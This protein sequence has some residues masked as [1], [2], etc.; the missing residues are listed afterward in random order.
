[1]SETRNEGDRVEA[2]HL[3]LL[4]ELRDRGTL[5]AVATATHRT[6]SAVS[7][8]LR[9]AERQ[10]GM[11]LAE[12]DGRRLRLTPAGQ[13]LAARAVE[14]ETALARARADLDA[15]RHSPT[16]RVRVAGLP[17]ALEVLVPSVLRDLRATAIAL[18]IED[19]DIAEEEFSA[20]ACDHDVVVAHSLSTGA[21]RG[22]AGLMCRRLAREPLDI[23]LPADHPLA[24]HAEIRAR[25][26]VS[27]PWIGV[28][29]GYPFDAVRLAV[30]T[31]TGRRIDPVV[32]LR[33]NHVVAALVAAGHG[34]AI[35]P[36]F[37]TPPRPGVV[38]RPLR[39]VAA[40]RDVVALARPDR[41]ERGAV[42]HVL[43]LLAAA[44]RRA[45]A[46]SPAPQRMRNP[47]GAGAH[48]G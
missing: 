46:D 10:V 13:A 17:S 11:R 34:V 36:R 6:P 26:V 42:R 37:T 27:E 32:R 31:A 40:R 38:T 21:P 3:E 19:V 12:P 47:S 30:E 7:Q 8:Q 5:A 39:D 4:R 24:G 1:M 45:E 25:E 9:A 41:A 18:T 23:A 29:L 35:L 48:T 16:G 28:P 44:G 20:L 43:T 14:V 33:D 2:R 15:L 22:A